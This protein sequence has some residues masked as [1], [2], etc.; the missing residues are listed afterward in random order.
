MYKTMEVVSS[1]IK[2]HIILLFDY[3]GLYVD[4]P[5]NYETV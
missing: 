2:I 1:L 5:N 3:A 4:S